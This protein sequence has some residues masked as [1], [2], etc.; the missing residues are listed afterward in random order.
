VPSRPVEAKPPVGQNL[1]FSSEQIAYCVA[2]DIRME[3]AKSSVDNYSDSDVDRFNAMVVDYNSRCSNFRYRRGALEGVRSSIEPYR[4][5]LYSEGQ[6]RLTRYRPRGSTST[7]KVASAYASNSRPFVPPPTYPA[8][9]QDSTHSS[10]QLTDSEAQSL[11]AAC[12]TD[13]YVNGAAAYRACVERQ[14]SAL[15]AGV[16]QPNLGVLSNAERESIDAACSTDKYINGPAAYNQC[17]SRKLAAMSGNRS[18]RP[19]LSRLSYSEKESIESAC[20]TDKYVNGPAA[21]NRCLGNQLAALDR[22]GSRPDLSG[23][24]MVDRSS[25]EAACSTE[26]YVSGPAEY[27]SCLSQQ[28][29]RLR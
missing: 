26:K 21:Y 24:S 20:S 17:L 4:S 18:N 25:I 16:R 23:L 7:P 11:E 1:V 5:E 10:L 15:A 27:N 13:K 2:E 28:L 9:Q 19:D 12:S 29:A 3:G 14:K 8:D 6:Q 22:Q